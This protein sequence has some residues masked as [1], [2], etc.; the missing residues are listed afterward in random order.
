LTSRFGQSGGIVFGRD[1]VD[2]GLGV[3]LMQAV[4]GHSVLAR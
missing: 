3:P 2:S 4:S 1:I